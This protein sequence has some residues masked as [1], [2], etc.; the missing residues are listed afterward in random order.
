MLR[1]KKAQAATEFLVIFAFAFVILLPLIY[2]FGRYSQSSGEQIIDSQLNVIGN[3]IVNAAESTFYM[4]LSARM[5]LLE[6]MPQGLGGIEIRSDWDKGINELV[7]LLANGE[8]RAFFSDV[9]ING[10]FDGADYS[11]GLKTILLETRNTSDTK[12]V[13]VIIS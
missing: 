6:S 1:K 3:D 7:I 12:Y 9:N 4:G 2:L 8:E 13:E 5:T 11:Q 10:S